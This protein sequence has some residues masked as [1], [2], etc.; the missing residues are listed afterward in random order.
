MAIEFLLG[1]KMSTE[2]WTARGGAR[3]RDL[4][5]GLWRETEKMLDKECKGKALLITVGA[6]ARG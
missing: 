3:E 1:T 2:M 6:T 4:Q 5:V